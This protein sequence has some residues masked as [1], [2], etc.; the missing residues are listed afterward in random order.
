MMSESHALIC[1]FTP[2][3]PV[4]NV[5]VLVPLDSVNDVV[6]VE[7][8]RVSRGRREDPLTL[9]AEV[10]RTA[11]RD[12]VALASQCFMGLRKINIHADMIDIDN[13]KY[14]YTVRTKCFIQELILTRQKG[15]RR[16]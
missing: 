4:S 15:I 14:R 16:S 12:L 2:L 9:G 1:L 6:V 10:C 7:S 13:V 3:S 5:V 8:G 11:G